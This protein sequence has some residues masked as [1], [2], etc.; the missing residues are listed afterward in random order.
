MGKCT[1]GF[2]IYCNILAFKK[3]SFRLRHIG[4]KLINCFPFNRVFFKWTFSKD[5]IKDT[6][7]V[8]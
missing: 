8:H 6:I 2:M 5:A 4:S 1:G 7:D 3:F